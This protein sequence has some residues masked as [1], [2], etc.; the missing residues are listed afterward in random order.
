MLIDFFISISGIV[1]T[2]DIFEDLSLYRD[3]FPDNFE[4]A[5]YIT[6]IG[7]IVGLLTIVFTIMFIVQVFKR[8]STFL[9]FH[10]LSLCAAVFYT[11]CVGIIPNVMLEMFDADFSSNIG[12][13]VGSIIGFFVFALYMSKSIRVRTYMGSDEYMDK[14]LFAF[15]NQPPLEGP[16][17]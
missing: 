16:P 12:M 7:E 11:I 6:L 9:L 3:F 8:K 1:E 2:I 10:Q 13:L 17:M 5:L 14:A 4:T 15:K